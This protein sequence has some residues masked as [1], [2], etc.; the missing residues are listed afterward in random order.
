LFLIAKSAYY[1]AIC[2]LRSYNMSNNDSN[3]TTG[4][5]SS[6][7]SEAMDIVCEL[8]SLLD[9]GLDRT[10]LTAL[11][12]LTE[13]GVAPQALASVVAELRREAAASGKNNSNSGAGKNNSNSG[14]GATNNNYNIAKDAMGGG[15]SSSSKI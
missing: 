6:V 13:Y 3:G 1:R 5:S 9:C 12:E 11:V 8:S 7:T 4:Q 15:R 10:A 14:A 2:V